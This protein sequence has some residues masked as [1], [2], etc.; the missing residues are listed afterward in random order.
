[1]TSEFEKPAAHDDELEDKE[2]E[3]FDEIRNHLGG[4][5]SILYDNLLKCISLLSSDVISMRG[6]CTVID[7]LLAGHRQLRQSFHVF[8][9]RANPNAL[10]DALRMLQCPCN[11]EAAHKKRRPHMRHTTTRDGI[12][13]AQYVGDHSNSVVLAGLEGSAIKPHFPGR[14]AHTV[15]V[16]I[17]AAILEWKE[18]TVPPK[19]RS[20]F[21]Q[22]RTQSPPRVPHSSAKTGNKHT[23]ATVIAR[24]RV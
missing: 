15:Q 9:N 24:E 10:D 23:E 4:R 21:R 14:A 7:G 1:M 11:L 18:T 12:A 19:R 13:N 3:Y 17:I 6:L 5:D 16:I 20:A 22:V 8:L 2:L